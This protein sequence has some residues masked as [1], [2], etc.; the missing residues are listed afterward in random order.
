MHG[1][2]KTV[3][4]APARFD[5]I[6]VR[7]LLTRQADALVATLLPAACRDGA[8]LCVGNLA[9]D[10]G[11]SLR[12]NITG[13]YAGH[14]RDFATGEHGDA[15]ALV[16]AVLKLSFSEALQWA[17]DFLGQ[18]TTT[19]PTPRTPQP[20]Q[21]KPMP[22]TTNTDRALAL[23]REAQ[24]ITGTLAERYLR[25]HRG[26]NLNPL[27]VSLRFHPRLWH[28]KAAQHF[29]ALIAAIQAPNKTITAVHRI[30]LC[31]ATA[32]KAPVLNPKLTLGGMN[33]GA[34]RLAAATE[35]LITCEGLED[36][37]TLLQATG[38]PVW[39]TLGTAGLAAVLLPDTVRAVILATDNDTPGKAAAA[40]AAA[41]F[42]NEKRQVKIAFPPASHK[43]FNQVLCGSYVHTR[44]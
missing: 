7:L 9:G 35:T 15:L 5:K 37:L 21:H 13:Q 30:F 44:S 42:L 38:L 1:Y 14:W 29:P 19:P 28:S 6:A 40:K 16:M 12:I 11:C 27:P 36:G 43:D 25:E 31:P 41:R 10:A 17:H 2:P 32:K 24:P 39:A 18:P 22:D 33:G 34:V 20:Q 8:H 26:I 3:V 4:A 23:W